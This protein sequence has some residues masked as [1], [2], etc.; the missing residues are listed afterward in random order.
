M[1]MIVN[2]TGLFE[3]FEVPTYDLNKVPGGNYEYIDKSYP[4]VSQLLNITWLIRYLRSH[5]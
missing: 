5:K 3:N 4:K 2:A 1:E